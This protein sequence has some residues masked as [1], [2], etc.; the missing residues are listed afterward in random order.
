MPNFQTDAHGLLNGLSP[1]QEKGFGDVAVAP[2]STIPAGKVSRWVS[3]LETLDLEYGEPG[4]GEWQLVDDNRKVVLYTPNGPYTLGASYFDQTYDGLGVLP[5][6]LS[7]EPEPEAQASLEYLREQQLAVVNAGFE[8]AVFG[9]TAAYPAT[10]RL[11]W[12][13]QQAEALAWSD[14]ASAS[15]PY[16]DG[17]AAV[18]GIPLEDMRQKTLAQVRSFLQITQQFIGLRQGLRDQ[19]DAAGSAA[20]V[21]AIVWP[22]SGTQA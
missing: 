3:R 19:I 13:V 21:K 2:P 8:Q 20:A 6:W 5:S 12:A 10:E 7:T 11:T 9:L 14:D 4:T 18:R 17:I 22:V 15:T 16:L 1:Y